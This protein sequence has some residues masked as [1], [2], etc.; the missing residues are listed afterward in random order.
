MS[1]IVVGAGLAGLTAA[2]ELAARGLAVTV[3]EARERVGGRTHGVEVAPG[4]WA[5]R[6]AAYLG[7]RH[8]ELR[9]MIGGLGLATVATTMTGLSRFSFGDGPQST[10]GRFPPL[11][12]VALGDLGHKPDEPAGGDDAIAAPQGVDHRL[13]ILHPLLLR[14]DHQ[15]VEDHQQ[16]GRQGELDQQVLRTA[17]GGRVGSA[18]SN[19]ELPPLAEVT[20]HRPFHHWAPIPDVGLPGI[21]D[22]RFHVW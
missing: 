4:Q 20:R 19:A 18:N 5:D 12:A 15:E 1:V 3:L 16:H 11:N 2:A 13:V 7:D 17:A 10:A 21:H 8:T 9:S 6:G 14:A 22:P